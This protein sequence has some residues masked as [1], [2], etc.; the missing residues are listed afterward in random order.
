ML[1]SCSVVTSWT[2][3]CQASLSFTISQSSLTL[4][5]IESVMQSNHLVFCYPL[6]LL[7]SIFPNIRAFS[8][9]WALYIRGSTGEGSGKPLQHSCLENYMNSMKRQKDMTLKNELPGLVGAQYATE[10]GQRYS[11]RRNKRLGQSGN[12]TQLWMCLM[13]KVK[14]SAVKNN[15]A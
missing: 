3:A 15:I 9:E 6:L 14:S 2:A 12:S 13:V 5:S 10:E 4:M 11:F 1:F 8:N 7:P